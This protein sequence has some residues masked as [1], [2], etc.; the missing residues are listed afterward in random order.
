MLILPY[1][2]IIDL[3]S[4][5]NDV[6]Y[7]LFIRFPNEYKINDKRYPTLFLLDPQYLFSV[8]YGVR[9]IYENYII[10]GIGHKDLDFKE[11]DEKT[12]G[13]GIEVNRDRDF[14][15]WKLD[16]KI[17]LEGVSEAEIDE[18]VSASGQAEKFAQFI[19]HQVIPLID[20]KFR[21]TFERTLIGH[22]FGGVFVSFMLF[23]HPENFTKYIAITP[24][25]ASEYYQEKKMFGALKEKISDTKKF[26]YFSIGGEEKDDRMSSYVEVLEKACLGIVKLS[27]IVGKVEVIAG[28]G[29]VSVVTPSIWRGLEFFDSNLS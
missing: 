29:H 15:P 9:R 25:L 8:C 6:E 13:H 18:I 21:T 11:L 4:G 28:E 22:S 26:A 17:F 14:L 10:V 24:V 23:C 7:S 12:R 5:Y 1:T 2:E 3:K 27:N 20:Q 19:N 16:K